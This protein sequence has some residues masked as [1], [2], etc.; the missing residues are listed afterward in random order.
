MRTELVR[1]EFR[2]VRPAGAPELLLAVARD[3]ATG[4]IYEALPLKDM[5][6]WLA[7]SGFEA[8]EG[9]GC[10]SRRVTG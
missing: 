5:A 6:A 4:M 3:L 2:P 7:M 9:T 1:I 10:W 8:R